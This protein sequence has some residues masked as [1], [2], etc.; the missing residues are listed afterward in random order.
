MIMTATAMCCLSRP[1]REVS[2]ST[3]GGVAAEEIS[4]LVAG[5]IDEVELPVDHRVGGR[6]WC[7]LA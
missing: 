2:C 5:R 4:R 3:I 7:S 1:H 6:S